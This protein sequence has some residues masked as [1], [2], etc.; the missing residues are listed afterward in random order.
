MNVIDRFFQLVFN[1][2]KW[3][4]HQGRCLNTIYAALNNGVVYKTDASNSWTLVPGGDGGIM[5]K[6]A[7]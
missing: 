1:Q 7:P 6:N 5:N 4:N 3:S 2:P